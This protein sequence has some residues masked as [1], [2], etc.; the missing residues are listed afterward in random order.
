MRNRRQNPPDTRG[1]EEEPRRTT[2]PWDEAAGDRAY[3]D[4]AAGARDPV[5]GARPETGGPRERYDATAEAEET[6][7]E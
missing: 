5:G 3:G 4:R 2:K 1:P 7:N 6:R